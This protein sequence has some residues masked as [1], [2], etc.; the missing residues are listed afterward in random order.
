MKMKIKD[1]TYG[2]LAVFFLLTLSSPLISADSIKPIT[3]NASPE[4]RAL[5]QFL[6]DI[7]GKF[8][9]TGQ[10]NYPNT[11]D[12]N[13]R[14]A[15]EYIGKTPVVFSTDWGFAKDGDTDSY[16]AR[17]DIVEEAKRQ[18]RLGSI[19][20]ICWHAVP[21]TA[22]EPV[23]F[24]PQPGA[25]PDSLVSVQGRLTDRQ[26][27]DVLTPGTRLNRRWMRQVDSIAVYLKKLQKARVPILWRPYHEMN[28]DW[29]W[30]GGRI[31]KYGTRAMYLQLF[32]R[33]VN[34]H[35]LDNLVWVWSVDRPNKPEMNFSNYFPGLRRLDVLALDVYGRDFKQ[36][37]YD[38]LSLL[39]KG[40]PVI[41]A[42]VGNP[43]TPEILN[44]QPGWVLYAIWAGMVR[45]TK[46]KEHLS[47]V[48]DARVLS[49][50][51]TAYWKA[52]APYRAACGFPP[53]SGKQ[54]RSSG[55]KTGFSGHWIFDEDKS[56]L[57]NWGAGSLP[58]KMEIIQ[59][60]DSLA[61]HKTFLVEYGDDTA[62]DEN[63]TLDGKEC[64]S[65]FRNSPRI[66]TA[67]WSAT[68]DTLFIES[69]I[70]L[71]RGGQNSEMVIR[72]AWSLQRPN[73]TLSI[74]QTSNSFRGKRKI[75]M[76]FN[77]R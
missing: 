39:S 13:T 63:L 37:Y 52:I 75:T 12:R 54:S 27:K 47:L 46:K 40:K 49:I 74:E 26:F 3:P 19:I 59:N 58:A 65:E 17:R 29:F 38:S 66:M 71:N 43:P 11:K 41:L 48:H 18:H 15:A 34:H 68:G 73:Q 35:K 21:P 77:R 56:V 44:S 53:L 33:L 22:D 5:L 72:E 50:E 20:T 42:E 4:A 14:F 23:T 9:L 8:T 31:G 67:N 30:W 28:G 2:L 57:D 24:R 76:I 32:D 45:N 61:V 25:A 1:C 51:D 60:E 6:H 69:K 55:M 16:L 10:H 64:K 70:M 7:S 36:S 62:T